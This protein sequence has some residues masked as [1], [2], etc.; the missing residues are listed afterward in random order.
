MKKVHLLLALSTLVIICIVIILIVCLHQSPP[1]VLRVVV[2]G[3]TVI[4]RT[5]DKPNV[6]TVFSPRDPE[7]LHA[8]FPNRLQDGITQSVHI[9]IP[10]DGLKPATDWSI[11]PYFPKDFIVNTEVWKRP[12]KEDPQNDY[13]V[14]I[15]LPLPEKITFAPQLQPVTL[16]DGTQ[17]FMATNVIFEYK[18]TGS[19]RIRAISQELN[20]LSPL[21]SSALQEQ[22]ATLCGNP[23]VRKKY[24]PGCIE[25]RNLLEQY[26][27]AKTAV[28]FFGVGVP[29]E[30]QLKHP[31]DLEA[32]AIN[33]FNN[34][35]LQSFPKLTGPRLA[36]KR[37]FVPQGSDDSRPM[38]M[39]TSFKP[40]S[41]RPPRLLPVT[42]VID[43]KAGN[44]IV[45][46]QTT[47]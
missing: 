40:T 11:D 41:P 23:D 46:A 26:A 17:S 18:V 8:F 25:V 37:T 12:R 4:V 7:G 42:A 36:P 47:Q 22:Y 43:C 14:T 33:F 6:L 44:M 30:E 10:P 34:V 16:D 9:T 2:T 21:S 35:M 27:G 29:L 24:Y 32:H 45:N 19:G 28:F 38:L 39:E 15:E 20:N 31:R 3:P 1:K 5:K 13:F